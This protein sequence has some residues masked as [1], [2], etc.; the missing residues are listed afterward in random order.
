M[1]HSHFWHHAA[2]DLDLP[3]YQLSSTCP[4]SQDHVYSPSREH[5]NPPP[6]ASPPP[7]QQEEHSHPPPSTPSPSSAVDGPFLDF[8]YPAQTLAFMNRVSASHL[9]RIWDRRAARRASTTGLRGYS[10][11]SPQQTRES[12]RE[13]S[14][15]SSYRPVSISVER[16]FDELLHLLSS[17]PTGPESDLLPSRAWDLYATL[18]EEEQRNPSLLQSLIV[19]LNKRPDSSVHTNITRLYNKLQET[20]RS[21]DVYRA[22][23]AAYIAS[24]RVDH[25][26][27]L[28][29]EATSNINDAT[30]G[31]DLLML[32]A[33]QTES[34]DM[35]LDLIRR[36]DPQILDPTTLV[37]PSDSKPKAH[38]P[39]TPDSASA[40]TSESSQSA[41]WTSLH[42]AP[43]LDANILALARRYKHTMNKKDKEPRHDLLNLLQSI[44]RTK[45]RLDIRDPQFASAGVGIRKRDAFRHLFLRLDKLQLSSSVLYEDCLMQLCSLRKSARIE[46]LSSIVVLAYDLYAKSDDFEPSLYLLHRLLDFWREQK[47]VIGGRHRPSSSL[48]MELYL[49]HIEKF[50]GQ[51]DKVALGTVLDCMARL[52][53]VDGV[54]LYVEKLCS[55]YPNGLPNSSQIWP[56]VYVYAT[57]SKPADALQQ[58][59]RIKSEF[60]VE[61]D[62]KCWNIVIHAYG[63]AN[64]LEG[65]IDMLNRL[66]QTKL[67]P[68]EYSFAPLLNL[69]SKQGDVDRADQIFALAKSH[70]VKPT[71]RMFNSLIVAYV[72]G[73]KLDRAEQL[74]EETFKT[75][76]LEKAVDSLTIPFN[77]I[78]TAY[79]LRRNMQSAMDTYNRMRKENVPLDAN[80]YA[81]IFR[82]LC[83][84]RQTASAHK[85]LREIMRNSNVRPL[86]F[87]YAILM[88]GYIDQQL[89]DEALGAAEEMTHARVRSNNT[90]SSLKLKAEAL[91]EHGLNGGSK[92]FGTGSGNVPL[93]ETVK[94]F[95]KMLDA[96]E[97]S[98]SGYE[99]VP[100]FRS[101][102]SDSPLDA[103]FLVFIHGKRRAFDAAKEICKTYMSKLS[104]TDGLS[105][106]TPPLRL[107]TALMSVHLRERDYAEVDR[108][109]KLATEQADSIR[110]SYA[111]TS[112][113]LPSELGRPA[114]SKPTELIP[115]IPHASR[116]MLSRALRY[117]MASQFHQFPVNASGTITRLIKSLIEIGLQLDNKTWNAFIVHLS[118]CSPPRALLAFRITEQLLIGNWPGWTAA[119]TDVI[120]NKNVLPKKGALG[121]GFEYFGGGVSTRYRHPGTLTPQYK[122]MVYLAGALL[123][124]KNSEATGG[125]RGAGQRGDVE[126]R[127]IE[128]Q[129]G[130]LREIREVAPETFKAVQHMPQVNN[131]RLQQRILR[132]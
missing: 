33:V 72:N 58:L 109:W 35:A 104:E 46:D 62:L 51:L 17:P 41:L 48:N 78:L 108:Y 7:P 132:R 105:E 100:E 14:P 129:V 96:T 73:D 42:Q 63:K 26:L 112:A 13:Y 66:L 94:D 86:A 70:H 23:I 56:L 128:E 2:G 12:T 69:Y 83:F 16:P 92:T 36:L 65:A 28:H 30:I 114:V 19:W 126:A 9:D 40:S 55:L 91:L 98:T 34:W 39:A 49:Q 116:F 80:T 29:T 61:P 82:V 10:T 84:Y 53:S 130:S 102:P 31:A 6:F 54:E 22:A 87:H 57:K 60:R 8:L 3:P 44:W 50:H 110:T 71:I 37:Q 15:N 52:G 90:I 79:A 122:T 5:A 64:D 4:P 120:T 119:K 93:E 43:D 1:L 68:D 89:Y 125:A 32:H 111:A 97:T 121:S 106:D 38:T 77:S 21:A 18:G 59:E 47:L 115:K 118:R 124:L 85:V 11:A 24:G 103:D 107:I 131:N 27:R 25:A 95:M 74:L 88:A 67:V 113:K 99:P 81:A 101:K 76:K 127:E 117:Y 75:A 123:E 45:L 20:D